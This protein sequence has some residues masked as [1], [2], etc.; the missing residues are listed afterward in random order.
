[1][2]TLPAS[3]G[4]YRVVADRIKDTV[5]HANVASVKMSISEAHQ[6]FGHISHAA[7]KYMVRTG[8]ITGIDLDPESKPDFCEACAKAKSDTKPFLKESTTRAA[9]YGERVHWDLWGPATVKSIAGHSY[10]A[11][12][13]DDATRENKLYSQGKKSETV[14]SYKKDEAYIKTQTGSNI[15]YS[16]SD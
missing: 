14:G 4:L 1:M 2:A 15:K 7:V 13:V 12:R 6:K 10:V 5:D 9:S 8:M 16:R 3:N 11:A